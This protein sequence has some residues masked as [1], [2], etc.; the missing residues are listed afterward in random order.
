MKHANI[1][2]LDDKLVRYVM[3][4]GGVISITLKDVKT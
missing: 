1:E 4:N 2:I 3:E